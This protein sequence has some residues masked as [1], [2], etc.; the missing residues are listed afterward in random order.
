[1]EIEPSAARALEGI[2][3][4]I[5]CE[6]HEEYSVMLSG[7]TAASAVAAKATGDLISVEPGQAYVYEGDVQCRGSE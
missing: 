5:S 3:S 1:M 7:R 6:R 2:R 4:S